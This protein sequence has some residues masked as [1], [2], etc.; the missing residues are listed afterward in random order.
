MLQIYTFLQKI[1]VIKETIA[2]HKKLHNLQNCMI[3]KHLLC[4]NILFVQNKSKLAIPRLTFKM[5][6]NE[7]SIKCACKTKCATRVC[8]CRKNGVTCINCSCDSEQ[9]QNKDKENVSC[10]TYYILYYSQYTYS[11]IHICY[12]F[13]LIFFFPVAYYAVFRCHEGRTKMRLEKRTS[14]FFLF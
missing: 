8:T 13:L 7:N 3:F 12:Q 9:C 4:L 6:P 14:H 1:F 10:H 11:Y 5:E 2:K